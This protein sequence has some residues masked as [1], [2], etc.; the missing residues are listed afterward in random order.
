MNRVLFHIRE[1][2]ESIFYFGIRLRLK[3]RKKGADDP[4][5]LEM[6]S[7]F[8]MAY[9]NALLISGY[10]MPIFISEAELI[11]NSKQVDLLYFAS[12]FFPL[13]ILDYYT[14]Y[15]GKKWIKIVEKFNENRTRRIKIAYLIT[16]VLLIN[17]GFINIYF[18]WFR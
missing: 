15:K 3:L 14:I 13:Y 17:I 9:I 12:A 5:V 6:N 4:E 16:L 7:K 10:Y 1:F 18:N 11:S 2:H 8:W